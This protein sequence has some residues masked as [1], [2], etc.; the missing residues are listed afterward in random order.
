MSWWGAC[1]SSPP[2]G[3]RPERMRELAAARA[4]AWAHAGARRRAGPGL[5]ARPGCC[6]RRPP[7]GLLAAGEVLGRDVV[8]EVLEL[9]DDLLLVLHLVLELDG[10]LGDHVL[11][12]EDRSAGADRQRQGVRRARVDL[13]LTPVHLQGHRRIEGVLAQ[14]GHGHAAAGDLELGQHVADQ[15]VGHRP[16]RVRPL[17]LHQDRRRL[18]VTDP[19]GEELVPLPGLQQDDRLLADHVEGDPVDDHLL[20]LRDSLEAWSRRSR[21]PVRGPRSTRL[22]WA[23]L[24]SNQGPRPYQRRALTD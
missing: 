14:L 17:E 8:E 23:I 24:D 11:G 19:D 22:L 1:W 7:P 5:S 2:H 20:H 3:P 4:P 13:Y 9:L 10:G 12:G 6:P 15:V 16:G 18:R 21:A